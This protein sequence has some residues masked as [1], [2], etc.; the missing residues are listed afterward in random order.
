MIPRVDVVVLNWNG[1]RDTI[2]CLESLQRQDYPHVNVLVVDNES[3]DGSVDH[4]RNAIPT[5]ELFQTGANLGFG[6]ATRVF[7][8][9]LPVAPT[10]SG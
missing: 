5:V 2:G 3:T 8:W 9:R 6:G 4:I 7:G 10:M 1:W